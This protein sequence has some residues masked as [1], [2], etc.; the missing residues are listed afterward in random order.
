[1]K[2][3]DVANATPLDTRRL[4]PQHSRGAHP[5]HLPLPSARPASDHQEARTRIMINL[6]AS[7]G[8]QN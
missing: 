5:P 2:A 8:I 6:H 1:L 3:T 4:M 7:G